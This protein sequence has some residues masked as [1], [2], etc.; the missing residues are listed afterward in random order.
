MA[1]EALKKELET[2]EAKKGQL[3]GDVVGLRMARA[4]FE[5]LQGKVES[6]SKDLEGAKAAE[7]LAAERALK[8]LETADNLH[9]EVDAKRECD[10]SLNAQ[11][12][13]LTKQLENAKVVGLAA[14]ELYVGT[15]GQF[16]GVTSSL[17]PTLLHIASFLR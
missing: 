2:L 5:N 12:D 9:K 7:Q 13:I 16:D 14:V 8:A 1:I 10:A 6:L 3:A 17:P 11:V 4:D 15:L